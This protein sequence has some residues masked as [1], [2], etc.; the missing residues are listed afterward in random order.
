[1]I[2]LAGALAHLPA[3][4]TEATH[5]LL[6]P[7]LP[8]ASRDLEHEVD[9]VI[10]LEAVAGEGALDEL[11]VAADEADEVAGDELGVLDHGLEV[12]H[13]GA[14]LDGVGRRGA[15]GSGDDDLHFVALKAFDTWLLKPE[16]RRGGTEVS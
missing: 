10:V 3:L 6:L 1:M 9:L 5:A 7:L 13:G 8:H 2:D 12:G 4:A 16:Y 15:R 11:L 14:A